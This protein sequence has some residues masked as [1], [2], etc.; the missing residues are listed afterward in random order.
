MI[1]RAIPYLIIAIITLLI[2]TKI[3][4]INLSFIQP[5]L[6]ILI[7]FISALT[8]FLFKDEI[9]SKFN[10]KF[11][12]KEIVYSIL[13]VLILILFLYVKLPYFE[14]SLTE[15]RFIK[16][17]ESV[18]PALNMLNS[19]N[20]T[21]FK[22]NY[23][24]NPLNPSPIKIINHLPI[25]EYGLFLTYKILPFNSLDFNTH[26][27]AFL[28]GCLFLL[29]VYLFSNTI[30]PKPFS[31]ILVLVLSLSPIINY[32]SFLIVGDTLMLSFLFFSLLAL[33]KYKEKPSNK[34]F[35]AS[36]LLF[37]LSILTKVS[38]ILIA[39][40]ILL[41]IFLKDE[42]EKSK[43]GA[44][45]IVFVIL[46]AFIV[47]IFLLFL[48]N[49]LS[50]FIPSLI[51][52]IIGL[53][54]IYYLSYKSSILESKIKLLIEKLNKN[55]A[56]K[57]ISWTILIAIVAFLYYY[58]YNN[59][60]LWTLTNSFSI[61][62]KGIYNKLIQDLISYLTPYVF[63]PSLIG[64]IALLLI[65]AENKIKT[66]LLSFLVSSILYW[67]LLSRILFFHDYYQLIIIFTF[68][69]FFTFV[70]YSTSKIFQDKTSSVI[71]L[72]LVIILL[73]PSSF[74]HSRE[75]ISPEAKEAKQAAEY[76]SSIM[77]NNEYFIS[78]GTAQILSLYSQR[79]HVQ[80]QDLKT[81]EIANEIKSKGFGKTLNKLNIT[82]FVTTNQQPE[83]IRIVSLYD[84]NLNVDPDRD[85]I[86]KYVLGDKQTTYAEYESRVMIVKLLELNKNFVLVKSIGKYNFFKIV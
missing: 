35:F 10:E 64:I 26:L 8:L 31:I 7:L 3:I 83:Y 52:I 36:S 34:L 56:T 59:Y 81:D 4:G 44:E 60:L 22:Y 54:I 27:F 40:P 77:N 78:G 72:V 11:S 13:F 57:S 53:I 79:K 12:K 84:K 25:Y 68:C 75:V 63:Y 86:I 55:K 41:F 29:S 80:L 37:A 1:K 69:L 49:Y 30:F 50:N 66:T 15:D 71:F 58:L 65:K 33:K 14:N 24:A 32:S 16:Y 17:Q 19:G 39:I 51:G 9:S 28:I 18:E 43:R 67:V 42:K 20:P 74:Q 21:E 61:L 5:H 70:I 48:R 38:S 23:L 6:N 46:T 82:Y 85:L 73:L 45:F 2:L 62:N 47:G 76:L